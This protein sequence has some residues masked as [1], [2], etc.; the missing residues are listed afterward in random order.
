MIKYVCCT[1]GPVGN[2]LAYRN[3]ASMFGITPKSSASCVPRI[4]EK[5]VYLLSR[6]FGFCR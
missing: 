2:S 3:A 1:N 6:E 5:R 4:V